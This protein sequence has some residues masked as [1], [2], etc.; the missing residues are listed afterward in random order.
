M[1]R[2]RLKQIPQVLLA[3]CCYPLSQGLYSESIERVVYDMTIGT[4]RQRMINLFLRSK[5]VPQEQPKQ[6]SELEKKLSKDRAN[7]QGL[8]ETDE[9]MVE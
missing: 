3:F 2:K 1:N 8:G 6:A 9:K 7:L 5:E 4:W